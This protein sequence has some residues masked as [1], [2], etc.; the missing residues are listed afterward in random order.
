[1]V[2]IHGQISGQRT[3]VKYNGKQK[4]GLSKPVLL[5]EEMGDERVG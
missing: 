2:G 1:M 3:W 5:T 4:W